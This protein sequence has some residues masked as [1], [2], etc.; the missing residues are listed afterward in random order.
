[1][2]AINFYL[3]TDK[4]NKKGFCPVLAQITFSNIKVKK[5]TGVKADLS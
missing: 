5:A 4:K 1:M 2:A 3:R